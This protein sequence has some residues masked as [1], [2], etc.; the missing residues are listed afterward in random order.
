MRVVND[1]ARQ[2]L[3]LGARAGHI[4]HAS[5]RVCV[6]IQREAIDGQRDFRILGCGAG[7]GTVRV[8]RRKTREYSWRAMCSKGLV[9][10]REETLPCYIRND[11]VRNV[12]AVLFGSELA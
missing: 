2:G 11:S 3:D 10:R 12:W 8:D 4:P 7:P 1:V 9:V 6:V 5:G